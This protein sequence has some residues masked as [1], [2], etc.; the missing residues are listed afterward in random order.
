MTGPVVSE[1]P[2]GGAGAVAVDLRKADYALRRGQKNLRREVGREI[3]DYAERKAFPI[4]PCNLCGSQQNLQRQAVKAM[5]A[6]W[7]RQHP[8]RVESIF[9]S[10]RQVSPSQLADS[11]LFPFRE[12]RAARTGDPGACDADV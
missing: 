3:A 8:G 5:L 2:P 10:I 4:I 12:L 6:N 9:R 11:D 7:E 1:S